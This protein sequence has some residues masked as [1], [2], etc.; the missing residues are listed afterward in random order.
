MAIEINSK[1]PR[2]RNLGG[3][4]IICRSAILYTPVIDESDLHSKKHDLHKTSRDDGIAIDVKPLQ[5]NANS[6]MR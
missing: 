2:V 1:S 5:Q 6:S 4:A 3:R